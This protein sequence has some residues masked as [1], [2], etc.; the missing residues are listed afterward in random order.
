[1][2][3]LGAPVEAVEIGLT[4]SLALGLSEPSA[5]KVHD[6]DF[7]FTADLQSNANLVR[8]LSQMVNT[9]PNLR[10]REHGKGW[11]VRWRGRTALCCAFF[12]YQDP[13]A[14]PLADVLAMRTLIDNVTIVG[15]VIDDMHS[16][17]VPS[18]VTIAPQDGV[19]EL[20]QDAQSHLCVVMSHLRS[21][22]DFARGALGAF[23]GS[24]VEIEARGATFLALSVVDGNSSR[25]LTPPWEPY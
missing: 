17:Y 23:T 5:P 25:L 6:I 19:H 12:M 22:G 20:P 24:L 1:M 15:R 13:S 4:G 9:N 2:S 11:Q 14:A 3:L 10:L 21:R 8:H 7:V 18:I 16:A